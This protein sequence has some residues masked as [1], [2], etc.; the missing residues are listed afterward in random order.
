[1]NHAGGQPSEGHH[2]ILVKNLGLIRCLFFKEF[3]VVLKFFSGGVTFFCAL[4]GQVQGMVADRLG[5]KIGGI[6]LKGLDGEIHFR[7]SG[8]D[9]DL[10]VRIELLDR[11]QNLETVHSRHSDIRDYDSGKRLTTTFETGCPIQGGCYLV[12]VVA[13]G[14]IHDIQNIFFIIDD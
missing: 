9:D 12:A 14:E 13:Q 7:E 6:E 4:K 1:M 8:T 2:F 10:D 3:C 5:D 11:L